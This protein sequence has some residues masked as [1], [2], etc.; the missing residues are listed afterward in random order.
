MPY[1]CNNFEE[2]N[3]YLICLIQCIYIY[4]IYDILYYNIYIIYNIYSIYIYYNN[5][6]ILTNINFLKEILKVLL[7]IQS[8]HC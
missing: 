5:N 1:F 6:N 2:N 3:L 7:R 8:F 4:N